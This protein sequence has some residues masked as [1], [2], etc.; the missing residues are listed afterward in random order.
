METYTDFTQHT[1]VEFFALHNLIK[2]F[3]S[4]VETNGK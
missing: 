1:T 3:Y 2:V 4:Q